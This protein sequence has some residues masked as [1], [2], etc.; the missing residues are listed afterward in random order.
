MLRTSSENEPDHITA[1]VTSAGEK[2]NSTSELRLFTAVS[3]SWPKQCSD[4]HTEVS[5]SFTVAPPRPPFSSCVCAADRP[6]SPRGP[7]PPQRMC[8]SSTNHLLGK[9]L[10]QGQPTTS[11][12]ANLWVVKKLS[13]ALPVPLFTPT[14]LLLFLPVVSESSSRWGDQC[15]RFQLDQLTDM[16]PLFPFLCVCVCV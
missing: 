15:Q 8:L 2:M 5:C 13:L 6:S 1:S 9:Q 12:R 11:I 4:S 3:C 16:H 7:P 14:H 10:L